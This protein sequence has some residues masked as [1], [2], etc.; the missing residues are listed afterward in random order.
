MTCIYT[1][2]NSGGW[3]SLTM[4]S[5]KL[6]HTAT[7]YNALQ[8]TAIHCNTL[9]HTAT[10]CNTLQPTTMHCKILPHT[11]THCNTLPHAAT[12]FNTLQHTSTA[13][14]GWIFCPLA[15]TPLLLPSHPYNL[16]LRILSQPPFSNL[17]V[18]VFVNLT[19]ECR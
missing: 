8:H 14:D 10:H 4:Y 12:H 7:H 15:Q 17:K 18:I 19:F 5:I 1:L 6:Q 2:N 3:L 13:G 11:V 9:Q 16:V